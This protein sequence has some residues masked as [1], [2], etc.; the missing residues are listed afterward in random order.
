[1][2]LSD[3][4]GFFL[5]LVTERVSRSRAAAGGTILEADGG[6]HIDYSVVSVEAAGQDTTVTS[7]GY[8]LARADRS[9]YLTQF[10]R[11]DDQEMFIVGNETQQTG[12]S[13]FV[14]KTPLAPGLTPNPSRET[15][16]GGGGSAPLA[17]AA[18]TDG[19]GGVYILAATMGPEDT[20]PYP[21]ALWLFHVLA[22]GGLDPLWPRD[23]RLVAD[24]SWADGT[25]K[26]AA[27][28]VGGVY[29][30]WNRESEPGTPYTLRAVAERINA[31]GEAV[32]GWNSGGTVLMPGPRDYQRDAKLEVTDSGGLFAIVEYLRLYWLVCLDEHGNDMQGWPTEG[33]PIGPRIS[34]DDFAEADVM[35]A[36]GGGCIVS[37]QR[38]GPDTKDDD[39]FYTA[40]QADGSV[41][42][43]VASTGVVLCGAEGSQSSA[44]IVIGSGGVVQTYWKDEVATDPPTTDNGVYTMRI[45]VDGVRAVVPRLTSQRVS[46]GVTG[47]RIV[48]HSSGL[49]DEL[50][51]LLMLKQGAPVE[52][53]GTVRRIDSWTLESV[54]DATGGCEATAFSLAIQE[55]GTWVG[56]SDTITVTC[57]LGRTALTLGRTGLAADGFLEVVV[58]SVGIRG[59]VDMSLFDLLGRRVGS[60]T[61][62][63][64][65][66]GDT[67]FR[68]P[69]PG[70]TGIVFLEARAQGVRAT[71][72]VLAIR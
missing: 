58:H 5:N 12:L 42:P 64:A 40:L 33:V 20:T 43:G 31:R 57:P 68:I 47:T 3:G 8:S 50:P 10:V 27:D 16:L 44:S 72:R 52:A 4:P 35:P 59:D 67:E 55:S 29:V 70:G 22:S 32:P 11:G 45:G 48:W 26:L 56:V 13:A 1:L 65:G 39:L 36:A 15:S 49:L 6:A 61:G 7:W 2:R 62:Q 23:G 18:A 63:V 54:V 41:W 37:W 34:F 71:K 46:Q 66:D 30:T 19:I 21:T 17:R 38:L 69:A 24:R 25:P 53:V 14:V 28:G 51:S 9:L 60:A